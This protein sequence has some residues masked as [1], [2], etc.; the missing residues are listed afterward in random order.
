MKKKSSSP[1]IFTQMANNYNELKKQLEHEIVSKWDT[2]FLTTS[3]SV[4]Q[5]NNYFLIA[6]TKKA[7]PY[8]TFMFT[9]LQK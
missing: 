5:S 8:R 9:L 3:Y 7:F 1:L 4:L 2:S 6:N